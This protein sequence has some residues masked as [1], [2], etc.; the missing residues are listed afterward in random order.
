M[1]LLETGRFSGKAWSGV[2]EAWTATFGT[3]APYTRQTEVSTEIVWLILLLTLK[4]RGP[5]R[6]CAA[7]SAW[8]FTYLTHKRE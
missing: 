3:S 6:L 2:S 8:L 4:I 7:H 5:I 1:Y